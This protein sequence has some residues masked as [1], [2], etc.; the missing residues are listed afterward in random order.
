MTDQAPASG[1]RLA[2]LIALLLSLGAAAF[3]LF[4]VTP[5]YV[6]DDAYIGFRYARHLYEGHG[7]VFNPGDNVEGYTSFLWVVMST[8]SFYVGVKAVHFMQGVS[9]IAQLITMWLVWRMG[10]RAGRS[11]FQALLAPLFLA[12]NVTFLTFPMTGMDTSLISMLV[13]FAVYAALGDH[14]SRGASV[15]LGIALSLVVLTRFDGFVMA[16][17]VFTYLLFFERR[18][19][20][21]LPAIGIVF[22]VL[23]LYHAWRL[24]IMQ[25]ELLP[26]TF[27]AKV[28]FG[29]RRLLHGLIYVTRFAAEGSQYLLVFGALALALVRGSQAVGLLGFICIMHFAYVVSVGGDWMPHFRFML[30]IIPLL[31]LLMQEGVVGVR[32][33]GDEVLRSSWAKRTFWGA[34]IVLLFA[35]NLAGL[36]KGMFNGY[37]PS[38]KNLNRQFAMQFEGGRFRP[39]EAE[40][41]GKSI[42]RGFPQDWYLAMEWAGVIPYWCHQE[43]LDIFCLNDSQATKNPFPHSTVGMFMTAEYLKSRSPDLVVIVA[44]LYDTPEK[45]TEDAHDR[46]HG[47]STATEGGRWEHEFYGALDG[48]EFGYRVVTT[49][50]G[51]KYWPYLLREDR[52]PVGDLAWPT[53]AP[54]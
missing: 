49:K 46:M 53:D 42:D 14:R 15:L 23:V 45:A 24:G 33:V 6:I 4:M 20:F 39:K 28:A 1:D 13:A 3:T 21:A 44:R 31:F 38:L 18:V 19:K 29:T 25:Y 7:L 27:H 12:T 41:I 35:F 47:G 48:P 26:N 32:R 54:E 10:V 2:P 52:E 9:V 43:T 37:R 5:D 51:D 16:G 34:T 11:P 40:V 17:I 30:P 22:G 8:L 36:Y 50:I